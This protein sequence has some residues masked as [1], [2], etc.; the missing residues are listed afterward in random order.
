MKYYYFRGI[1]RAPQT[2]KIKSFAAIVNGYKQLTIVA[3]HSILDVCRILATDLFLEVKEMEKCPRKF[4][5]DL[6]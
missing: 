6:V 1:V 5:L 2:Y 3:K 4:D